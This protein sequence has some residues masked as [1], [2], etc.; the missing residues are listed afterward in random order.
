MNE[1]FAAPQSGRGA[2]AERSPV[3]RGDELVAGFTAL[4]SSLTAAR[5]R[6]D[7]EVA[8]PSTPDGTAVPVTLLT[9]FLGSGKTTVVRELL[10]AGRGLRV[11]AIVNDLAAVNVDARSLSTD[12]ADVA[13]LELSNGCACC[14]LVD[15]LVATLVVAAEGGG[16][17]D[18]RTPDAIVVEASGGADPVAMAASIDAAP[19]VR[20]DGI[21]AVADAQ[22]VRDQLADPVLGR[23]A[24]RQLEAA[25]LVLLS[26]VD[27][28]SAAVG[29][30]VTSEIAAIAPGRHVLPAP[31]G[32]VDP[33]V[34]LSAAAR[35][36][37]LPVAGRS[38]R[39]GLVTRSVSTGPLD[40]AQLAAWLEGDHGLIRAKGWITD[41]DGRLHE[42]QVVGRRWSLTPATDDHDPVVVVIAT[43]VEQAERAA[44]AMIDLAG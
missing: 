23:L 11:S 5:N 36:A 43:T 40:P 30:D 16:T 17:S 15:D 12:T 21:V 34:L 20:L 4:T 3:D 13:Q 32:A 27:L 7:A 29:A 2:P 31:N 19:G 39:L 42:L 41:R 14:E 10:A 38:P 33:A 6:I 25:H 44:R 22:A 1:R 8:A 28:V 35:G 9:G 26:K 24:R 18:R 37:S